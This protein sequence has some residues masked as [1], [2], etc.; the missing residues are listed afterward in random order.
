MIKNLFL[1]EKLIFNK[2]FYKYNMFFKVDNEVKMNKTLKN[3]PHKFSIYE[4]VIPK[5]GKA[6]DQQPYP[7]HMTEIIPPEKFGVKYH[8]SEPLN[9]LYMAIHHNFPYKK[10][11]VSSYY[12]IRIDNMNYHVFNAARVVS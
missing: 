6:P 4:K 8:P 2:I 5:F 9:A 10:E 1:K 11:S 12:S 7:K 3:D